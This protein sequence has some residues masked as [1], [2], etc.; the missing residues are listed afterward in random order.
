MGTFHLRRDES[1]AWRWRLVD[2]D[3]KVLAISPGSVPTRGE[4]LA[5]VERVRRAV[6][7]ADQAID[8]TLP[9][10]GGRWRKIALTGEIGDQ[11]LAEDAEYDEGETGPPVVTIDKTET[12]TAGRVP[13]DAA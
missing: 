10:V 7:M 1:G 8:T 4:C 12:A 2:E 9:K 11:S 13:D 3:E 5:A 6:G